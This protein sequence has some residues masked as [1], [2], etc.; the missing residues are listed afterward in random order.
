MDCEVFL[1]GSWSSV[2]K[3]TVAN[4]RKDDSENFYKHTYLWRCWVL[5]YA[6]GRLAAY[7][8]ERSKGFQ[9]LW[10][11]IGSTR[12]KWSVSWG[13]RALSMHGHHAHGNSMKKISSFNR[14]NDCPS[15][16][17]SECYPFSSN[18]Q[19]CESILA[20]M[21]S[22]HFATYQQRNSGTLIRNNTGLVAFRMYSSNASRVDVPDKALI[23]I[24]NACKHLDAADLLR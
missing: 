24:E 23:M 11:W 18:C 1:I 15:T 16:S 14:T 7:V 13:C 17:Q 21:R 10:S 6:T 19:N 12:V 2:D 5:K 20:A 22:H 8:S 3:S 4:K 9:I